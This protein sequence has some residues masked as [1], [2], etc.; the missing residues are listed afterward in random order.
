MMRVLHVCSG[1]LFGG[2][3]TLL[4]S[5][6]EHDALAPGLGRDF[7][8]CFTGRLK[9]RLEALGA[10]VHE[11]GEVR[12]RNPLSVRRAR[13]RL[14][15]LLGEG[16]FDV[17]VTHSVWSQ[18]LF[19]A[20]VRDAGAASIFW[21]HGAADG[22]HW[23]ERLASRIH[24]DFV[25]A[26]S[27]YTRATLHHL[28]PDVP[29]DVV[30]PP[31]A[32]AAPALNAEERGRLRRECDT[33]PDAVVILQSSRMEPW[34]GHEL[35]L[36][37][38][39]GLRDDP[40]WLC[41]IAG[42][43]QR[44]DEAR[45]LLELRQLAE[46]LGIADRVRFLGERSDIPCLLAAADIHCQANT[47]PEPFGI[48]F[49]EALAA[50]LPVVTTD[51]GGPREIV[52]ESCGILVRPDDVAH[53]AESLHRLIADPALRARLGQRGPARVLELCEPARQ[54]ARLDD[55]C[56]RVRARSIGEPLAALR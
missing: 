7:A 18:A 49:I 42:A 30:Y 45:Y 12:F 15:E 17:V 16:Q 14:A 44:A 35:Q 2:I 9:R 1:N 52:D 20:T 31:L 26:N 38:L 43:S 40:R 19:G 5:L 6:A 10:G 55:I 28:Y 13:R 27:R 3:E 39:A 11:L 36:R 41:W 51:L 50:G 29:S 8:V 56:A 21:L 24:P 25:I 47:R 32:A 34:K 23:L 48:V 22:R 46:S 37:A 4:C 33:A 53:L 54:L